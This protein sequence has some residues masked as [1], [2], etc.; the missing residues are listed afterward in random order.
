[1]KKDPPLCWNCKWFQQDRYTDDYAMCNHNRP[2]VFDV[3]DGW[4]NAPLRHVY[5]YRGLGGAC[6]PK[7]KFWEIGIDQM[8]KAASA[9]VYKANY[10]AKG[11]G[12]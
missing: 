8:K 12:R 3:I 11:E 9:A 2:Q 10:V 7:G 5:D 1:M 4:G 6:G